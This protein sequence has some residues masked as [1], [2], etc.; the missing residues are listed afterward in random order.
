M[1]E[2]DGPSAPLPHSVLGRTMLILDAFEPS[3]PSLGFAGI[4]RR[5]GLPKATAHRLLQ[6]LTELRLLERDVNDYRLGGRLFEL[7][8]LATHQRRLLE[9]AMPF[10]Q[11]LVGR[12]SETVHLAVRDG[13]EV[14]YVAKVSGHRQVPSPSRMGGRMPLHCTAVGKML[15]AH[16]DRVE[17][18]QILLHP[19]PRMTARTITA[20]GI[21]ARQLEKAHASG[22]STE[23]EESAAGL[24]CV[25]SPVRDRTGIVIAAMSIAGA[26]TRFR[27][28]THVA[29]V[30]AAADGV[31]AM[32]ARREALF[33]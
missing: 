15:L 23:Y 24:S 1:H 25:A 26:S 7:G 18:E 28:E 31:A 29:D 30:C 6:E 3:D 10:M 19:L 20:P 14:V 32:I 17:Q 13:A 4:V 22:Y 12:V 11:D 27:P 21:L 8:M 16:A 2:T 33:E 5:T 9:V